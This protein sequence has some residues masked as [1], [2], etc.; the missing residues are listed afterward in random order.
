MQKILKAPQTQGMQ[1]ATKRLLSETAPNNTLLNAES[2]IIQ[3]ATAEASIMALSGVIP[4]T[5]KSPR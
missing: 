5:P 1:R 2:T 4:A 3:A